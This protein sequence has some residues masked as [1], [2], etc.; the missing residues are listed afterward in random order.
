MTRF[1]EECKVCGYL[2]PDKS[3]YK[4]KVSGSCPATQIIRDIPNADSGYFEIIAVHESMVTN[5][6]E[7]EKLEYILNVNCMEGFEIIPI[8]R[9]NILDIPQLGIYSERA[10]YEYYDNPNKMVLCL[11]VG[12]WG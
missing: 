2:V 6:E 7:L 10:F 12:Y 3:Y 11:V 9:K 1:K 8:A 5:K 4:C